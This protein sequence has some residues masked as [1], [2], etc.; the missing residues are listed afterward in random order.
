M[1]QM[2]Y[3]ADLG[4]IGE[5]KTSIVHCIREQVQMY[6][7][8]PLLVDHP[9]DSA[10]VQDD[11]LRASF[12]PGLITGARSRDQVQYFMPHSTTSAMARLSAVQKS[13]RRSSP[14]GA[15]GTREVGEM[16]RCLTASPF[17]IIVRLILGSPNSIH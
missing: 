10:A 4:L 6:Q 9:T 8:S 16:L 12:L 15:R 7:K 11:E 14:S 1:S 13:E 3:V 17:R 5:Y 2:I